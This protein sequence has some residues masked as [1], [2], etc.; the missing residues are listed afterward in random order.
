[1][2]RPWILAALLALPALATV[3]QAAVG[4][5]F[6]SLSV[7]AFA[8]LVASMLF[9]WRL[10]AVCCAYVLALAVP[11]TLA[12]DTFS[13]L[14][15]LARVTSVVP[16][17]VLAVVNA[18]LRE[19]RE[20]RL[21]DVTAVAR[22]AQDAI[23]RELPPVVAGVPLAARYRSAAAESRV[24]GD[25]Y[26]AVAAPAGLRLVVGDVRGKGLEA[27]R[28]AAHTVAAFREAAHAPG[29]SLPD[30][31][32]AVDASTSR[33]LGEEDFVTAVVAELTDAGVLRLANCGHP[34]PVVLTPDGRAAELAPARPTTPLGL[35]PRPVVEE[36]Q[37]APGT[38]VLFYSDGLIEARDRAGAFF[39][40]DQHVGV[41]AGGSLTSALDRL[42]AEHASFSR[43]L[44]DDLVVL[45]LEVPAVLPQPRPGRAGAQ[46]AG[47]WPVPPRTI[48]IRLPRGG[49][50]SARAWGPADDAAVAAG[51]GARAGQTSQTSRSPRTSQTSSSGPCPGIPASSARTSDSR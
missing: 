20:A 18:V 44:A 19:R 2:R 41:L 45:V 6:L 27:V 5:R 32:A 39:S 31:V 51:S 4:T 47:A 21:R 29:A 48:T 34:A 23:L 7:Y 17:L 36:H 35:G 16:L 38:R 11:M 43:S 15:D 14:V 25:L 1:M 40:L 50:P 10:T 24:G 37:L 13:P 8:P 12:D 22:V 49:R 30:V 26:E 9:R 3:A 28:T 46:R 42:L 33:H